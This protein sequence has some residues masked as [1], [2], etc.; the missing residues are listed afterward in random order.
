MKEPSQFVYSVFNAGPRLCLG[1]PL[2]LM[3]IKL[4]TGLL[5]QAFDLEVGVPHKGG[6][7]STLVLPMQPGLLVKLTP[8]KA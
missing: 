6:Y 7:A 1:K 4:V 3:E 2:A 8:R 5:L